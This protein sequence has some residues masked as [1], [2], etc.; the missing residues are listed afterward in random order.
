MVSEQLKDKSVILLG[1]GVEG[2][3]TYRF[4]RARYPQKS[5]AIA[6]ERTRELIEIEP[7]LLSRVEADKNLQLYC[8]DNY[9]AAIEHYEIII[10]TPGISDRHPGIRRSEE[11]GAVVTS[12]LEIFFELFDRRRVIG[13]TGT[14]G[15]S[16]TTSLIFKI[17]KDAG[18]DVIL[19]GNI[20]EP[21]LTKL[22]QA[23]RDTLFVL[24]LSSYQLERLSR[25]PHIAVLLNI[26]PEHLDYHGSFPAY[27]SAKE[28]V[29]RF[30][31]GS[32]HLIF[33]YDYPLPREIARR[34]EA[35][36]LPFSLSDKLSPGGYIS[37]N[38]IVYS[39]GGAEHDVLDVDE[40]PLLGSFNRQNVLAAVL[41]ALLLRVST[42]IIRASVRSFQPLPHRLEFVGEVRGIRFY[43]DSIS[44]VP[45][46][47]LSAL[48][49]LGE[50]VQTLILGG[51]ERNIDYTG[52]A[53]SLLGSR[54]ENIILFPPT[55]KRIW[56]SV[57][58]AAKGE[59]VHLRPFHVETM[60]QAIKVAFE[61]T[62][63]GKICLLS[64][65]SPSYSNFKNYRERGD[66]FKKCALSYAV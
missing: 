57:L 18:L 50:N 43:N 54:V 45:E 4:L 62:G 52:F 42:D 3:A 49:A 22:H 66:A 7:E 5:I 2:Q 35:R 20:G 28:N 15:K 38:T 51:H 48:E 34:T 56:D 9:L 14:K 55:G 53:H 11:K 17:L 23:T 44:T 58:T 33:N 47:T 59:A 31:S 1:F 26:V 65:A 16:T 19:G 30:Q 6:D 39:D 46:C 63:A 8:G 32:D 37:G 25:S 27:V 12:H 41:V 13:I 61:H 10:K 24:E 36:P 21:P 64:P 29:T 40:I 60:E